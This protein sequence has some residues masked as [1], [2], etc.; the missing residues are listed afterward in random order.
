MRDDFDGQPLDDD[1]RQE[2]PSSKF[3]FEPSK[4]ES[5]DETQLEAQGM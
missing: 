2:L 1:G 5:V 4:W 3:K